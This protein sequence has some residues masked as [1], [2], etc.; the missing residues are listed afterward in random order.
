MKDIVQIIDDHRLQY[1]V[2][3]GTDGTFV[4]IPIAFL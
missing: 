1:K 4:S 2:V 3:T